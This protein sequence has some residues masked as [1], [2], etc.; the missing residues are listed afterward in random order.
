MSANKPIYA[1][2]FP[3]LG[4]MVILPLKEYEAR[5]KERDH[6][7][8]QLLEKGRRIEELRGEVEGLKMDKTAIDDHLVACFQALEGIKFSAGEILGGSASCT[9]VYVAAARIKKLCED[10]LLNRVESKEGEEDKA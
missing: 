5:V 4:G 8:E 9:Y 3:T 2:V 6:A 1:D 10:A 7:F